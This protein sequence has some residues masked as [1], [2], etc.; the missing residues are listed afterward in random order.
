MAEQGPAGCRV[1]LPVRSSSR[2]LLSRSM[3]EILLTEEIVD[4]SIDLL[5]QR[6]TLAYEPQLWSDRAALLARLPGVRALLVRNMTAVDA[7]VLD[8]APDLEVVGRIGVGLDNLDIPALSDRGIV[9]CYPPEEN[10]V[11]VAEHVFALLLG[12]ARYVPAGDRCVREGRWDRSSYT[13]FEL[14]GKTMGILGLGRVGFRVAV[15]ARA[16]GMAVVAYDP[17]LVPQHS[18][19]TESGAVLAPLEE[20]LRQADVITCHLPLTPETRGL[21]NAE[22]LLRMK[23]NAVIINTSRGPIIEE[24]ALYSA[25]KE[26]II[27]GAALDVREKE[28]PGPGPLHELPNVLLAP[29][30]AGWTHEALHRVISTVA[31]EVDRVLSGQPARSYVNF[32]RPRRPSRS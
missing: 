10:A 5:A 21:I 3:A 31:E 9:V 18:F 15:R 27:A 20:V 16:F 1:Q 23:P 4:A 25:L 29:H 24:S 28:P 6:Y 17:Y 32:A 11:S 14:A 7:A 12:L 19:V 26:G 30:I 2:L 22:R 13:G 8:A